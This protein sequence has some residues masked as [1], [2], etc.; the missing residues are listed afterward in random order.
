MHTF[1]PAQLQAMRLAQEKKISDLLPEAYSSE[2]SDREAL[3]ELWQHL[4]AIQEQIR[5]SLTPA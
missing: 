1:S 5:R 3:R 4:I 2:I